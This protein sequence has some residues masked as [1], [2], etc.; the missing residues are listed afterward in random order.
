L[1]LKYFGSVPPVPI[2]LLQP[3]SYSLPAM[4]GRRDSSTAEETTESQPGAT[5]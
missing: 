5:R 2:K 3:A 4:R 1:L